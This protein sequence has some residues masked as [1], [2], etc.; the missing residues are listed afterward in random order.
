MF[1]EDEYKSISEYLEENNFKIDDVLI[2]KSD[3]RI[4]NGVLKK[5]SIVCLTDI[6]FDAIYFRFATHNGIET[7][8]RNSK[9]P[10]QT[11]KKMKEDFDHANPLLINEYNK[12]KE[13]AVRK[14]RTDEKKR[15]IWRS[16]S[17]F[18]A[19]VILLVTIGIHSTF[20]KIDF[21]FGM[22]MFI[23]F[24]AVYLAEYLKI[25]IC[26][27]RIKDGKIIDK[28]DEKYDYNKIFLLLMKNEKCE[29]GVREK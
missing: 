16:I 20:F 13:E 29:I 25:S 8:E 24:G 23:F 9:N 3:L 27:E 26:L 7:F 12:I 4:N 2:T 1:V 18:F 22:S 19:L 21:K 14:Y 28:F 15:N 17:I 6:E 5:G 10:E 11:I